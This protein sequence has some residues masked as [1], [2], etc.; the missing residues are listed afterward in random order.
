MPSRMYGQDDGQTAAAKEPA[1]N[2]VGQLHSHLNSLEDG[3]TGTGE[4]ALNHQ[5]TPFHNPT[6]PNEQS[7]YASFIN[8]HRMW[9]SVLG[10]KAA[11]AADHHVIQQ[12]SHAFEIP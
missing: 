7:R 9:T 10:A 4:G 12:T 1:S 8:G 2:P 11:E 3:V 5:S 6:E